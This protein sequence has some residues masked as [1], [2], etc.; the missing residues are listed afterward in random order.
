MGCRREWPD[1]L[2]RERS[3]SHHVRHVERESKKKL[4][5]KASNFKERNNGDGRESTSSE[6]YA[7]IS[8]SQCPAAHV[9]SQI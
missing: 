5:A 7:C 3:S 9:A 8:L 6:P 4:R 1:L 2:D